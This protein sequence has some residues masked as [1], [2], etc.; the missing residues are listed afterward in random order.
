MK[1]G[2]LLNIE[3]SLQ[4]VFDL[5]LDGQR[6]IKVRKLIKKISNEIQVFREEQNSCI[7]KHGVDGILSKETNPEAFEKW[8]KKANEMANTEVELDISEPVITTEDL[9]GAKISAKDLDALI[10]VGLMEDE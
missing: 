5:E 9:N 10:A 4:K 3:D 7:E 2:I 8:V 1:L 6:A